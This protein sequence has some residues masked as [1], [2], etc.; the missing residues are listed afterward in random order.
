M[1]SFVYLFIYLFSYLLIYLLIYVFIYLFIYS[2]ICSFVYLF[3]YSV[4]YLLIYLFIHLFIRLFIY[5]FSHLLIYLFIYLFIRLF[6]YSFSYLFIYLFTYLFIYSFTY[7]FINLLI[8]LFIYL[9]IRLFIY[10]FIYLFG[11]PSVGHCSAI[12]S[13]ISVQ[14]AMESCVSYLAKNIQTVCCSFGYKLRGETLLLWQA[15]EL[16]SHAMISAQNTVGLLCVGTLVCTGITGCC[17][18][19]E[20]YII[21]QKGAVWNSSR[22]HANLS[23]STAI[24]SC[25][26]DCKSV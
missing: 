6:I 9:F 23:V 14:R 12:G 21:I 3:V 19:R 5:L 10:L 1:Y 22:R 7:L 15:C 13:D 18:K 20:I 8:Y 2:F 4:I 16:I 24:V 25:F 26:L 17:W 11:N